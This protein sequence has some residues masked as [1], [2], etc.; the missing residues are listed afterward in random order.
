MN[1]TRVGLSEQAIGHQQLEAVKIAKGFDVKEDL[2]WLRNSL[3]HRKMIADQSE[4][5]TGQALVNATNVFNHTNKL[6]ARAL[7]LEYLINQ[8]I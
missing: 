3:L 7:G 5:L 2:E 1:S 4:K 6:I 8:D